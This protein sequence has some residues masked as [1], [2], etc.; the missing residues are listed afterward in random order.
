MPSWTVNATQSSCHLKESG[1]V[2]IERKFGGKTNLVLSHILSSLINCACLVRHILLIGFV[3]CWHLLV[4]YIIGDKCSLLH[5]PGSLYVW[6]GFWLIT[7]CSVTSW[8]VAPAL[9]Y[10]DVESTRTT[11]FLF[12]A[13]F[14]FLLQLLLLFSFVY[15]PSLNIIR[16]WQLGFL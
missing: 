13:D 16:Y 2:E 5:S 6:P 3:T 10:R 12:F 15:F 7:C 4:P 8:V 11:T 9:R 14:P 1:W